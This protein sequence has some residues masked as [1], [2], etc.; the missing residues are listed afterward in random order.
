MSGP[1]GGALAPIDPYALAGL[2]DQTPV[3]HRYR[4][5]DPV[6]WGNPLQPGLGGCWYLTR[7]D[8][9]VHLLKD[10]R[11]LKEKRKVLSPEQAARE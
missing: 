5:L 6:H 11:F 2:T 1:A 10:D 3:F 9:V 8:D 4:T 7:Y